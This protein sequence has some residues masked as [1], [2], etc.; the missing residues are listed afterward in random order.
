MVVD[1]LDGVTVVLE[2]DGR[3]IIITDM[4]CTVTVRWCLLY[5]HLSHVGMVQIPGAI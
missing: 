3:F 1:T 4:Q 2:M 5:K